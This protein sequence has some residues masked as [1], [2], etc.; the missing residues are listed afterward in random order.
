MAKLPKTCTIHY[1][2]GEEY[3]LI[4]GSLLYIPPFL[5][6]DNWLLFYFFLQIL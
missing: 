5:Q 2:W 6:K 1:L 3:V 4:N